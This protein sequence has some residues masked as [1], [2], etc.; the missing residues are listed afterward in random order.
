[1]NNLFRKEAIENL[2]HR[3]EGDVYLILP[4]SFKFFLVFILA[5]AFA[6]IVFLSLGE[7]KKKE[8][9]S[10]IIEPSL[11]VVKLQSM[12]S[13]VVSTVL[14]H[15]GEFVDKGT[16]IM[17]IA[18]AMYTEGEQ[19]LNQSL[20]EKYS[21]QKN[22]LNKQISDQTIND[23]ID[24]D[25]LERKVSNARRRLL[26]LD[27]NKDIYRE[28][29]ILS[30]KLLAIISQ[31]ES[32]AYVSKLEL[33]KTKDNY[34]QLKLQAANVESDRL[35]ILAQI[36]ELNLQMLQLPFAQ[37]QRLN[38]MREKFSELSGEIASIQQKKEAEIRA[39]KSGII[40]N[41]LAKQGMNVAA[42][43]PLATLLPEGATLNA[44]LYIPSSAYGFV[45][46]GQ[47]VKLRYH[48][49]PYQKFG[50][51]SGKIILLSDNP[52]LPEESNMPSLLQSPAYRV[53][54]ELASQSVSAYGQ[55]VQIKAGML[56]DADI[57]IEERS[58]IRWLFD[59]IFSIK[60]RL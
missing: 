40:T 8:R 43:K 37:Q 15:E 5:A 13:G 58:L 23:K 26:E 21:L 45:K 44:I 39:P 22:I 33:Q 3:L 29:L 9:V 19:E 10:G 42:H 59:P 52:T 38:L 51:F 49:F 27:K 2:R 56:L 46:L 48:A 54:V 57:I 14:V 11:G 7:Y 17:R 36:E 1:M 28:R 35:V 60:G 25:N 41:I 24:F 32:A 4:P 6:S 30:E 31:S 34:L 20:L 12:Q 47:E 50:V 18:S 53:V 16:P 55:S